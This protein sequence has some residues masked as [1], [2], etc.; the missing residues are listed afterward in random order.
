MICVISSWKKSLGSITMDRFHQDILRRLRKNIVDDLDVNNGIIL[1]LTTEYILREEDVTDI[2]IGNT[3]QERVQILL[4]LLPRFVWLLLLLCSFCCDTP[5]FSMWLFVSRRGPN[6]FDVFHQAL[7][8]HYWWL[9]ESF[10]NLLESMPSRST[11]SD[12]GVVFPIL[13]PVSP[14]TVTREEKVLLQT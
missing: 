10:D 6:A 13:Q 4:D 9:S 7:K 1:P 2:R 11:A 5:V 3:R 8:H 12:A 14:L